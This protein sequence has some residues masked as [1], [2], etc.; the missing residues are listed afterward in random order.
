MDIV[1]DLPLELGIKILSLLDAVSLCRAAQVCRSWRQMAD[2]DILWHRM[3]EQHIDKK[4]LKCGWGLPLMHRRHASTQMETCPTVGV[5]RKVATASYIQ[6]SSSKISSMVASKTWKSVYAERLLVERNWRRNQFTLSRF[7][8]PN[9]VLTLQFDETRLV[10]GGYDSCIRIW[11]LATGVCTNVLTGHER[12]IRA[13]QFDGVKIISGSMDSTIKV[14]NLL[15]GKCIRTLNHHM[16]G[17]TTLHYNNTYLATGSVDHTICVSICCRQER[18]TLAKHTGV[19]NRVCLYQFS[20]L[21]SCSDD[22]M[23]Y[24]WDLEARTCMR[25]FH[26]HSSQVLCLQPS[27]G[28]NTGR[29]VL[30]TGSLDSTIRIWDIETGKEIDRLFG[31]VEGVWSL[32]FNSLRLMSGGHDPF[33]LIYDFEERKFMNRLSEHEGH[34]NVVMTTDTKLVVGT[35]GVDVVMYDFGP[36]DQPLQ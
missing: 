20:Q 15:T 35:E 13:L 32:Q 11:D 10:T 6:C 5:D 3:C 7:P 9:G 14:W 22:S 27:T 19:I 12:C 16:G 29:P 25:S 18:F 21:F 31:H 33:L 36:R 4:C 8:H 24:L 26:G 1:G 23:V 2:Q 17:V 34:V 30:A 28:F